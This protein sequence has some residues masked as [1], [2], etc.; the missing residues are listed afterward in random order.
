M[1]E[2]FTGNVSSAGKRQA[3][4]EKELSEKRKIRK[5]AIIVILV[6]VILT[7]TAMFFNSNF[8]RRNLMAVRV[9]QFE[10]TATQFDFFL[11][12]TIIDY[13]TTGQQQGIPLPD[14]G[15]PLSGQF[16]F[17]ANQ[18]WTDYFI[19]LTF[20]RMHETAL[21]NHHAD[22]AGFVLSAEHLRLIEEELDEL[23]MMAMWQAPTFIDFLRFTYSLSITESIFENMMRFT[24]RARAF[25]EYM[26]ESFSYTQQQLDEAYNQRRDDFDLF[27]FR[28]FMIHPEEI[29]IMAFEPGEGE[30]ILELQAEAA[31]EAAAL[32]QSIVDEIESLEG[33]LEHARLQIDPWGFM[34]HDDDDTLEELMGQHLPFEFRQWFLDSARRYGDVAALEIGGA[35]SIVYFVER[36]DNSY[37]MR[38]MRQILIMRDHFIDH[39]LEDQMMAHAVADIS[40]AAEASM[41]L[42]LFLEGGAT[43]HHLISLMPMHSHDHTEGG[44]YT[45]LARSFTGIGEM[46]VVPEISRWLFEEGRQIGDFEL[47]RTENFGYHLIFLSGFGERYR[48]FLADNALRQHDIA[49][50]RASLGTIHVTRHWPMIFTQG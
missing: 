24:Y 14:F 49:Q 31:A 23:R 11:N 13:R 32:A 50:W 21:L 3:R 10:F 33:F 19:D 12:S 27:V 9:G 17:A 7:G 20:Q 6:V 43:E 18:Y 47:I 35:F 28:E 4:T 15:R 8:V 37:L 5:R 25:E 29:D 40:A 16:N 36:N 44:L 45:Q 22:I 1:S 2:L 34:E 48:D 30:L 46:Q 41:I 38:E 42:E 39:E 26:F